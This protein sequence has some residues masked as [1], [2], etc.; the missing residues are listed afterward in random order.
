MKTRGSS[1]NARA[2]A[3]RMASRYVMLIARLLLPGNRLGEPPRRQRAPVLLERIGPRL[4][5][6]LRHHFL[7]GL[8]RL[9]APLRE[10]INRGSYG[11]D[12]LFLRDHQ[13]IAAERGGHS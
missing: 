7:D 3:S 6:N 4:A 2:C 8:D 12:P 13:E 11:G 1:F 9:R 10:I 5:L